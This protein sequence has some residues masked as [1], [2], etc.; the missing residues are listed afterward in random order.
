MRNKR[1]KEKEGRKERE[2]EGRKEREKEKEGRKEREKEKEGRKRRESQRTFGEQKS[3]NFHSKLSF[4]SLSLFPISIF[5]T[6]EG[7]VEEKE[8]ERKS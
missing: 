4:S 3:F 7:R 5:I 8:S 1:K 2:K 6:K